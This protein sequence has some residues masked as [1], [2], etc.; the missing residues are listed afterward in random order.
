MDEDDANSHEDIGEGK[1][2]G[3]ALA[4]GSDTELAKGVT[5]IGFVTRDIP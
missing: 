4:R 1:S 5:G 3:V 2:D